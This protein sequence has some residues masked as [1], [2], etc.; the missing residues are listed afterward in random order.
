MQGNKIFAGIYEHGLDVKADAKG[1]IKQ[2]SKGIN[3]LNSFEQFIPE[4]LKLYGITYKNL[5]IQKV[6]ITFEPLV[7]L[8]EGPLRSW[9]NIG[10]EDKKDC[11][12]IWVWYLEEIQP[13]LAK[14]ASFWSFLIKYPN[15]EFNT[16]IKEMESTTGARYSDSVLWNYECKLFDELLKDT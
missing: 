5:Q 13:Y 7:G 9:M 2:L 4:I 16:I 12:I 1:C 11:K 14:G 10:Q 6:I 3:Q 15:I 8:N